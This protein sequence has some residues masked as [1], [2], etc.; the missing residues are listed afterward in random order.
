MATKNAFQQA[1]VDLNCEILG[2]KKPDGSADEGTL[3]ALGGGRLVRFLR[4][5]SSKVPG[6]TS[7][8]ADECRDVDENDKVQL[9]INGFGYVEG[10]NL[11]AAVSLMKA[12]IS[13]S[14]GAPAKSKR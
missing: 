10:E 12:R 13:G 4:G 14:D 2:Y 1:V 5:H 11:A 8:P 7:A 3:R 6:S 9:H